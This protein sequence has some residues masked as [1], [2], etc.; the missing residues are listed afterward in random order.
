M[1]IYALL[2]FVLAG[3]FEWGY[4]FAYHENQDRPDGE[5][6]LL[7]KPW[8]DPTTRSAHD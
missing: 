8:A 3:G 5:R 1:R 7:G 2:A 6:W 4:R